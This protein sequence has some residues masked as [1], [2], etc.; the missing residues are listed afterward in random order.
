M[1][2]YTISI[3]FSLIFACNPIAKSWDVTILEGS[4]VDRPALYIAT[5][6]LGVATDVILLALPIPMVLGLQMPKMQ[7]VGLLFMFAIGSL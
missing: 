6:V 7:K 3:F 2:G 4:C 1:V 5:A